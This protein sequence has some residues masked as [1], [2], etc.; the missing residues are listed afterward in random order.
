MHSCLMFH[1]LKSKGNIWATNQ[2]SSGWRIETVSL[3]PVPILPSS[4]GEEPWER[5]WKTFHNI[6]NLWNSDEVD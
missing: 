3:F 5:V 6:S 1:V 4:E 2:T